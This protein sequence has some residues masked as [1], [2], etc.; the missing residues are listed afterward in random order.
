MSHALRTAIAVVTIAA[1][2]TAFE[3][4]AADTWDVTPEADKAPA[5]FIRVPGQEAWPP[6]NV[7]SVDDGQRK[8]AFPKPA[9]PPPEEIKL[10][11]TCNAGQTLTIH[12]TGIGY[13]E[14]RIIGGLE[15]DI[16]GRSMTRIAS[17]KYSDPDGAWFPTTEVTRNDQL[18]ERLRKGWTAKA[19]VV[20]NAADGRVVEVPL[21]GSHAAIDKTLAECDGTDVGA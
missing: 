4:R 21:A 19:W 12:V 3:A 10:V 16:D 11:L 20:G 17:L 5:A 2:S 13:A 8:A 7:Q 18:V 14:P 6:V 1:A 15:F 9:P